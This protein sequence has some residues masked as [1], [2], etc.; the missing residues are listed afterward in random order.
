MAVTDEIAV[1]LGLSTAD[2]KAALQDANVSLKQFGQKGGTDVDSLFAGIEHHLLGTRAVATAVGTALGLHLQDIAQSVAHFITDT[3]K[4]EE[5]ALNEIAKLGQETADIYKKIYDARNTAQQNL[6]EETDHYDNLLKTQQDLLASQVAINA[7][8]QAASDMGTFEGATVTDIVGMKQ[9]EAKLDENKVALAQNAKDLAQSTATIEELKKKTAEDQAKADEKTV[10][11]K[12]QEAEIEKQQAKQLIENQKIE[13][14]YQKLLEKDATDNRDY[15]ILKQKA[16]T[17]LTQQ[18]EYQLQIYELQFK[19]KQ[20]IAEVDDLLAKQLG[21][22]LTPSENTRLNTLISQSAELK[23]QLAT[24]QAIIN[25]TTNLVPVAAAVTDEYDQQAADDMAIAQSVQF[26]T[27]DNGQSNQQL[28]DAQ[29]QEKIANLK[30]QA[31]NTQAGPS[32]INPFSNTTPQQDF[33]NSLQPMIVAAQEEL[34]TRTQFRQNAGA[35]GANAA[36]SGVSAFDQDRYK[37][38]LDQTTNTAKDTNLATN[39]I[40]QTITSI[41]PDQAVPKGGSVIR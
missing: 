7:Q 26:Q 20:N 37:A 32:S 3:S 11:L 38:Y 6:Q 24:I 33:V 13:E 30:A 29:L 17:G 35:F 27:K 8:I 21:G 34:F 16:L 10:A 15:L 14:E 41:F 22:T 18:E 25:A 31:L 36:L 9:A 19:Q 1:K 40:L 12:T 2:F 5:D 4:E 39:A 23:T 28:T